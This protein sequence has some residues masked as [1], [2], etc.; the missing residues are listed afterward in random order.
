MGACVFT[1][2]DLQE[3]VRNKLGKEINYSYPSQS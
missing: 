3:K 1:A 2:V